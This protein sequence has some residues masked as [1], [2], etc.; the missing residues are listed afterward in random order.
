MQEAE[1][2][3]EDL[4]K[5]LKALDVDLNTEEAQKDLEDIESALKDIDKIDL[6]DI[7]KAFQELEQ[8]GIDKNIAEIDKALENLDADKFNQEI[9][10][11]ADSFYQEKQ[12]T[13]MLIGKQKSTFQALK[14]SGKQSSDAY[15]KLEQEIACKLQ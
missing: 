15:S 14:K 10:K 12:E 1:N 11:L 6:S 4:E 2:G 9:E 8:S 13:E 5:V 7:E 3:A